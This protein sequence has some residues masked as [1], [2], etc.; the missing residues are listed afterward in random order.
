MVNQTNP[1]QKVKVKYPSPYLPT[2]WCP[3]NPLCLPPALFSHKIR[4]GL[5]F[6]HLPSLGQDIYLPPPVCSCHHVSV[7]IFLINFYWRTVALQHHVSLYRTARWLSCP[8]TY[9]PSF[10][11]S[12]PSRSP[13]NTDCSSP[14]CRFS[15]VFYFIHSINSVNVSVPVSQSFQPSPDFLLGIHVCSLPLSV[16][17]FLLCE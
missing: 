8:C 3:P 16:S 6:R 15:L 13:Q 14:C 1:C 11:I 4:S 12:F 17:L 9:I 7:I 2:S 10:Q 5:I